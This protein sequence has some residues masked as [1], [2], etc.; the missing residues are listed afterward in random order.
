MGSFAATLSLALGVL[1]GALVGAA[2]LVL[3]TGV[4][5]V[6]SVALDGRL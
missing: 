6:L 1:V 3:W 4:M 5:D 2:T